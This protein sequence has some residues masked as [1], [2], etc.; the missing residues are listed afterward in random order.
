MTQGH[1]PHP[2]PDAAISG[3]ADGVVV[4]KLAPMPQQ[5]RLIARSAVLDLMD[6]AHQKRIILINAPAGYGKTTLLAQWRERLMGRGI[7]VAWLSLDDD[8]GGAGD[9]V[10]YVIHSLQRGGL[11]LPT[12]LVEAPI[13]DDVTAK[14][15][16]RRLLNHLAATPQPVVLVL[17]ELDHLAPSALD[18]VIAPLIRWAPPNLLIVLAARQPPPLPLSAL[19]VQGLVAEFDA[20]DL[21]FTAAEIAQLFG[22]S[23]SR[24]DLAGI[25]S[26]TEGWPVALQLLRGW[27]DQERDKTL[28]LQRFSGLTQEIATYLSEQVFAALPPDLHHFLIESSVLDRL[29]P[30]AVERILAPSQDK[31]DPGDATRLWRELLASPI[32]KPF[33]KMV[34]EDVEAHSLHPIL[35]EVLADAFALLPAP[36]QKEIH[37]AAA[38]WCGQAGYLTRA[39]RHAAA[40][41]DDDL[42]GSLIEAAGTVQI[43]IRQGLLRARTVDAMVS[44]ALLAAFPR[45][46][47]LRALILAK[48]GEIARARE[49]FEE[50]RR[51]TADFTR[52]RPGGDANAL[53]LDAL[54]VESTVTV[55]ECS[56]VSD[57]YLADYGR[58][59]RQVSGDDHIFQ[60]NVKNVFSIACHQRGLFQ[61]AIATGHEAID[62]YR[63]ANLPH[64]EFFS[65]LHIGVAH[66]G[67][68]EGREAE[69]C[70]KRA[71]AIARRHFPDDHTKG[72]YTAALML[73][74]AY[75]RN[76]MTRV[77]RR[78]ADLPDQLR[79]SEAWSDMTA[80]V[81]GP[82][83][84]AA[85]ARDGIGAA[86]DWLDRGEE[87]IVA[88]K[89]RGLTLFLAATRISCLALAGDHD[90]AAAVARQH[91]LRIQD[92]GHSAEVTLWREDEAVTLAMIRL[93]LLGGT[94]AEVLAM[95]PSLLRRFEVGGRRRTTL[96]VHALAALAA[97]R[98]DHWPEA[99]DHLTRALGLREASGFG[100]VFHEHDADFR[101]LLPQILPELPDEAKSQAQALLAELAGAENDPG[102]RD[103]PALTPREREVL[104]ALSLGN[105]DKM[106][107]RHLDLTENTVKYHLKNLYAKLQANSRTQA[108]HIARQRDLL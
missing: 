21:R 14:A 99:R 86:L 24:S 11:T 55:N 51:D 73:E 60:A 18:A 108:I 67:R 72:F 105:T 74:L 43:W 91:K 35:R 69:A 59:V 100:R 97:A 15:R 3:I 28:L 58:A 66:F 20:S 80:A 98:A 13:P 46:R 37:R 79:Q 2:E 92:F 47:L 40:A 83:S 77:E 57:A 25:T 88:R 102:H 56:P 90:R 81:F 63:Q 101:Q 29:S 10:R 45:L 95:L 75:E 62:H 94:S 52:D 85:L 23:L 30:G 1:P 93:A 9:L 16:L 82:A 17:D 96:R 78:M 84:M 34:D 22:N 87:I 26:H 53:R 12:E 42:A 68:A 65:H 39:L 89:L 50:V 49:L 41:G 48:N 38:L 103:A 32:L 64:G 71:Q 76:Q 70:Y 6:A 106:I 4:T 54:V 19:R 7:T 44:D 8:D 31:G 33:L 27:W 36:R 61:R 5:A 104:Q 107:A